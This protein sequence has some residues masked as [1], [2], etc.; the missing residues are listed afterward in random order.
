MAIPDPP[1]VSGNGIESKIHPSL[2]WL[3]TASYIPRRMMCNARGMLHIVGASKVA[4]SDKNAGYAMDSIRPHRRPR[5]AYKTRFTP[6]K[7]LYTV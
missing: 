5:S 1:L 4:L 6:S 3:V 7:R 2:E